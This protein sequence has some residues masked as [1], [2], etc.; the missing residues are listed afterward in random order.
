MNRLI[1]LSILCAALYLI[2]GCSNGKMAPDFTVSDVEGDNTAVQLSSLR[3]KVVVLDFW[4]TWCGPCKMTIPVVEKLF[5]DYSGKGVQ[6]LGISDDL[7]S[8]A[9]DFRAANQVT[10][11][12][13]VDPGDLASISLGVDSIPNLFVINKKGEIVL[14][15][16]GAPLDEQKVRAA[17]DSCL[18]G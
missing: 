9:R 12:M 3:G 7:P 6:F 5:Q 1:R 16:V 2:S 4:A 11:K 8:K 18:A 17:I 10:Y 13:Y 14:S 15:E